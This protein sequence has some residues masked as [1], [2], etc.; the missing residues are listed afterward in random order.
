MTFICQVGVLR[1]G[2]GS[3][4]R[5]LVQDDGG[6]S[7]TSALCIPQAKLVPCLRRRNSAAPFASARKNAASVTATAPSAMGKITCGSAWMAATTAGTAEKPATTKLKRDAS[8]QVE[9]SMATACQM[10]T[11]SLYSPNTFRMA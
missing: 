2:R 8:V 6:T 4:Y 1:L 5:V 11:V 10:T 9:D 3:V 7:V